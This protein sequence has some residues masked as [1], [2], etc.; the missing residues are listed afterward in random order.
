MSKDPSRALMASWKRL[1]D[2]GVRLI[3]K[4]EISYYGG[5]IDLSI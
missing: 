5:S 2:S 3:G 1:E 4:S